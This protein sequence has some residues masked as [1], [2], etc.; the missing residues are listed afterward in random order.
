MIGVHATLQASVIDIVQ[1]IDLAESGVPS[2]V[3]RD[4]AEFNSL[5]F[6]AGFHIP[7]LT[8]ASA[9]ETPAPTFAR[10]QVTYIALSK[11]TMPTLVE[12]YMQFKDHVEIYEDGTLEAVL[13][14]SASA[15]VVI[16]ILTRAWR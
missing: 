9:S 16:W 12:L 5:A 1:T 2:L 13:S 11:K 6:L 8:L 15:V 10:K 14:V 4:L 7:H 3:M